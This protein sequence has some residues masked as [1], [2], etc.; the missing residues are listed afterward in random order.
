VAATVRTGLGHDSHPFG[1]GDGLA[2]GGIL[3]PDAPALVGHSDGDVALHAVADALLGAVALGDLGRLYPADDHATKGIAS[4]ALVQGVLERVATAGYEPRGVDLTIIAG[5]PRLD[6]HLGAIRDA[7][8]GVLGLDPA[9]VSVKASTG[10]LG[11]DEGAGRT[12]SA[13]A[14]VTVERRR[15]GDGSDAD[16]GGG[17]S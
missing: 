14:I 15:R 10:N 13:R 8:A 12:V 16:P 6:A 11:G 2:L 3:I 5:R 7:L 17:A 9:A 4:A 1:P